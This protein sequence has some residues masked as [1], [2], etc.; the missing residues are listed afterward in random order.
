MNGQSLTTRMNDAPTCNAITQRSRLDLVLNSL[1]DSQPNNAV[2]DRLNTNTSNLSASTLHH[3]LDHNHLYML[4]R[5]T[6]STSTLHH[7]MRCQSTINR[8]RFRRLHQLK[9]QPISVSFIKLNLS[10]AFHCLTNLCLQTNNINPN[11]YHVIRKKKEVDT[12]GSMSQD[13]CK[14]ECR[15]TLC[16]TEISYKML[17]STTILESFPI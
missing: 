16:L 5:R 11:E 3:D 2:P 1:N 10:V 12:R 14:K 8:A 13:R 17:T 6:L 4:E 7:S 9:R 15:M